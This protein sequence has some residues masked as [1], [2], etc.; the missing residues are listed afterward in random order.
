MKWK[1]LL[2]DTFAGCDFEMHVPGRTYRGPIERIFIEGGV[3]VRVVMSWVAS[4]ETGRPWQIQESNTLTVS[5]L[6]TTPVM[7]GDASIHIMNGVKPFAMIHRAG[8]NLSLEAICG[9]MA[10]A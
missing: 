6:I 1:D 10:L 3:I 9:G 4:Q 7:Q 8:D 2:E 5:A